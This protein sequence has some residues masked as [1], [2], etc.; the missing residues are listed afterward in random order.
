MKNCIRCPKQLLCLFLIGNIMLVGLQLQANETTLKPL[1]EENCIEDGGTKDF[2]APFFTDPTPANVTV[3][4]IGDIPAA[5]DLMADDDD[6][7]SFPKAI[8]PVDS[9]LPGTI[10]G[11]TEQVITRTW[12]AMDAGGASTTVTQ[13]ITVL[14]DTDAPMITL[15]V[16]DDTVRCD[17]ADFTTWIDTRRLEVSVNILGAMPTITDNCSTPMQMD[18]APMSF[19]DDCGSVTVTFT[20]SDDCGNTSLWTAKYTVI[21]TIG[22]ELINVPASLTGVDALDCSMAVPAPPVVTAM[23]ACNTASMVTF[24]EVNTQIVDGSC[25]EYEYTV[26]RT[27]SSTDECGNTTDSVQVIE[28]LITSHLPSQFRQILP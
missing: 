9:P 26:T 12:T 23:D 24:M 2:A 7:P 16:V 27:W 1:L 22:P 5:I 10:D 25:N 28:F 8:S 4:C 14:A 13:L 15:P 6:D 19:T 20:I 18:D 3:D 21:D 17:M 11:C